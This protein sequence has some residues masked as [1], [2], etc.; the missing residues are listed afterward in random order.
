MHSSGVA[1]CDIKGQNVLV[2]RDGVLKL[3]DFGA[4]RQFTTGLY[5]NNLASKSTKTKASG[6]V[7][8]TPAFIAPEAIRCTI[9]FD[10]KADVWSLGCVLAEMLNCTEK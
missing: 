1:H 7:F 3:A 10:D 4:A 9:D 2:S 5:A 8:G 6:G